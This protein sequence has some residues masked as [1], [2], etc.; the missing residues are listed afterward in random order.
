MLIVRI[1][2]F[3]CFWRYFIINHILF[4]L[5]RLTIFHV[6]W[7]LLCSMLLL[8]LM[9]MLILIGKGIRVSFLFMV[10]IWVWVLTNSIFYFIKFILIAFLSLGIR[11]LCLLRFLR[12]GTCDL[13]WIIFYKW[14]SV[15]IYMVLLLHIGN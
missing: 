15:L 9:L 2:G 5:I 4:F 7:R 6:Y 11:Y 8:M 14:K 12:Q 10:R 1:L 13:S 3:V